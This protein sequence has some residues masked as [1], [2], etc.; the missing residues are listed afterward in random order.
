MAKRWD[1]SPQEGGLRGWKSVS[2]LDKWDDE[3]H[4]F[5]VDLLDDSSESIKD[6]T[7][8]SSIYDEDEP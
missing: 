2:Y 7:S 1:K 6:D 3:V 5:S 4:A 8:F